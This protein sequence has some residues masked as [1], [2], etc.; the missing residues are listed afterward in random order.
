MQHLCS[1]N[2]RLL[3]QCTLFNQ[4]A[5]NSRNLFLWNFNTQ[6]STGNH[7]TVSYFQNFVNIIYTFLIFNLGNDTDVTS[8]IIQNFTDIKNILLCTHKRM[9]YVVYITFNSEKNIVA[10]FFCQRR[11]IDAHTW[12]IHTLSVSE[13]RLILY[14]T[15]QIIITFINHTKFKF[16]IINQDSTINLQVLNKI[17]IRNRNAFTT[18]F[19]LR[20]PHHFHTVSYMIRNRFFVNQCCSTDFR[21]FG[22]HKNG[23]TIRN[24]THI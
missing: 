3:C 4:H 1:H 12:H 7:H 19:Q 22:I 6:I 20:I 16:T 21:S 10:V 5:L 17:R 18:S 11:Q 2:Y 15:Q 13:S 9:C 8:I 24:C 14:L 23:D